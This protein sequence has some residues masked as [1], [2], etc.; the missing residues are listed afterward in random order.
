MPSVAHATSSAG[1]QIQQVTHSLQRL[2]SPPR[3]S[4]RPA[5]PASPSFGLATSI[6]SYDSQH[7]HYNDGPSGPSFPHS[8]SKQVSFKDDSQAEQGVANFSDSQ[9]SRSLPSAGPKPMINYPNYSP[10][11][12][13]SIAPATLPPGI[14][15]RHHHSYTRATI[16]PS[17][18]TTWSM[19]TS[20]TRKLRHCHPVF[21]CSMFPLLN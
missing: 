15:G 3:V 6:P 4:N 8:S 12:K 11:I 7:N 16:A 19:Q 20:R 18:S 14:K 9:D 13:R 1:H 2:S 5:S 21:R 17:T 10:H